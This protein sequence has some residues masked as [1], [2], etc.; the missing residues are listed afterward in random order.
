[1]YKNKAQDGKNN[2]CGKNIARIRKNQAPKLSQRA[3]ADEMQR[4]GIDID[5]N[6]IQRIESGERFVTDIEL[7]VF[8]KVLDTP[9]EALLATP[10]TREVRPP[11]DPAK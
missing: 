3:L 11:L 4:I 2:L 5:K 1:M 9:L 6:A 10:P 7:N 8:S